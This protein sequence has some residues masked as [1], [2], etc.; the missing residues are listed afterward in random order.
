MG[1]EGNGPVS[2][3]KRLKALGIFVEE[4]M[5]LLFNSGRV[6]RVI[7]PDLASAIVA[8][9]SAIRVYAAPGIMEIVI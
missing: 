5:V 3:E 8:R 7:L 2:I 4:K 9:E 1:V 6:A